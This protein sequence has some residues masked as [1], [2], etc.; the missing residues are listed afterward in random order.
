MNFTRHLLISLGFDISSWEAAHANWPLAVLRGIE[1]ASV[2]ATSGLAV[3]TW[4][5]RH[6][7]GA[8]AVGI[9]PVCY[10]YY[11]PRKGWKAQAE[12]YLKTVQS[13]RVRPMIDLEDYGT[14][15]AYAGIGLAEIKPW[16]EYVEQATGVTPLVYSSPGYIKAYLS[17]DT[18]IK[19][20]PLFVAHV[21]TGAPRVETPFIP[22]TEAAWQ[23]TF[24]DSGPYYG[25]SNQSAAL[26]L[27]YGLTET[28]WT[29]IPPAPLKQSKA[30]VNWLNVR[31][32]PGGA[33]T[34]KYLQNGQIVEVSEERTMANG[35]VW[36]HHPDGW[37]AM[38]IVG[39][40]PYMVYL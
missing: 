10:H 29:Y 23:F 22:M 4:Y 11:I 13:S 31:V 27:Y 34:G 12:L 17:R 19:R 16:L 28:P 37:S 21:E 3:D 2:R 15:R 25:L 26:A 14:I 39:M 9:K 35:D 1:W 18:W 33:A 40:Q 32:S 30:L 6:R 38:Q 24:T 20:Y 7:D 8:E 5:S 36:V